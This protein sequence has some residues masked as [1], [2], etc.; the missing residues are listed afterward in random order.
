MNSAGA[1]TTLRMRLC[2][3]AYENE[4]IDAGYR[5]DT[6]V[7][8]LIIVENKTVDSLA[9]IHEAQL[10]TYLRLRDLHL[11]FLLNWKVTLMKH[12]IKPMVRE[13]P[14]IAKYPGLKPT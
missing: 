9:P 6:L 13:L 3:L 7:D 1:G 2:P 12:R 10:L 5:I 14:G 11:R 4:L 8:G